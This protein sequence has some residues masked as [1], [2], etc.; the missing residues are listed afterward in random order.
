MEIL[1]KMREQFIGENAYGKGSEYIV[2]QLP[3]HLV[4]PNPNQPRKIFNHDA[5]KELSE[6]IKQYGVIQP[7]TVRRTRESTSLLPRREQRILTVSRQ[8]STTSRRS[9]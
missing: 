7:V 1:K 3:I 4:H 6:S 5:L 8:A 9:E 2:K